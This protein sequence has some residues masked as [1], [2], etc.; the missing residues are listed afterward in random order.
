MK[1]L[2]KFI[3]YANSGEAE[4]RGGLPSAEVAYYYLKKYPDTLNT[5]FSIIDS[6]IRKN[7]SL[8]LLSS[9]LY[10]RKWAELV[11]KDSK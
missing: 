3:D 10:I 9:S 8:Y 7:V 11:W 1:S 5:S 6:E 2:E 4:P